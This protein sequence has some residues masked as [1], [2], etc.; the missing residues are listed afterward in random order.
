MLK[1]CGSWGVENISFSRVVRGKKESDEGVY[2][3]LA[4]NSVGEAVSKNASL[5][6]AG[7]IPTTIPIS[8]QVKTT[9]HQPRT[10]DLVST[11]TTI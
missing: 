5:I 9:L 2:R 4:R 6:I 7:K 8:F 1:I 11:S 3:C 10:V